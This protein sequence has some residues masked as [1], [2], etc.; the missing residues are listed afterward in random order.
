[1]TCW[2]CSHS[3]ASQHGHELFKINKTQYSWVEMNS[4]QILLKFWPRHITLQVI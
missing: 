1:M 2:F 3:A 4:G